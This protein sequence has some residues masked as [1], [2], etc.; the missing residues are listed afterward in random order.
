ML[1]PSFAPFLP[2]RAPARRV[3]GSAVVS[4]D[5]GE[6]DGDDDDDDDDDDDNDDDDVDVVDVAPPPGHQSSSR[7]RT[8]ANDNDMPPRRRDNTF[9]LANGAFVIVVICFDPSSSSTIIDPFDDDDENDDDDCPRLSSS[10]DGGETL[11]GIATLEPN[12]PRAASLVVVPKNAL[13]GTYDDE[14]DHPRTPRGAAGGG[15]ERGTTTYAIEDRHVVVVWMGWGWGGGEAVANI[16]VVEEGI[17]ETSMHEAQ[18][19][20]RLAIRHVT[21]MTMIVE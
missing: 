1:S 11:S 8:T 20:S 14:N 5:G 10:A 9:P 12:R 16:I 4:I 2:K 19:A 3:P 17:G 7:M 6:Y 13:A 15:R 21:L 18:A